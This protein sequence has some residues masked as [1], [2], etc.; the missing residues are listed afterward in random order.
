MSD[1]AIRAETRPRRCN[2]GFYASRLS[3]TLSHS[4]VRTRRDVGGLTRAAAAGGE[5]RAV[6][7]AAA[8][9]RRRGHVA[10]WGDR[11]SR[12]EQCAHRVR[13]ANARFEQGAREIL[14]CVGHAWDPDWASWTSDE[15]LDA[16]DAEAGELAL[17]WIT[18]VKNSHN[19]LGIEYPRS[20]S[21]ESLNGGLLVVL[22][23]L[24]SILQSAYLRSVRQMLA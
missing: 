12:R 24:G 18:Y 2:T 17:G 10:V 1:L 13:S 8:I 14:E 22:G 20:A 21:V 5:L 11:S 16:Q 7:R 23:P 9:G 6:W 3:P 15:L 19:G 4:Q